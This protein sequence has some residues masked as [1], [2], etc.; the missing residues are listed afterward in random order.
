VA[1]GGWI[2]GLVAVSAIFLP[3]LLLVAGVVPFWDRLKTLAEARG[4]LAGVNAV[5]VGLL[6]AALWDPVLTS[7]VQRANDWVLIAAAYIFLTVA[8]LPAWLVVIGFALATGL[9]TR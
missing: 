6:A 2:G 4:A 1:P 8:K 7:A 5:V 3:S 9:L